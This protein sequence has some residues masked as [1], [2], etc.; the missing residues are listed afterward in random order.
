MPNRSRAI[1]YTLVVFLA[2]GLTGAVLMN[3]YEHFWRHP[4][5]HVVTPSSWMKADREHYIE[6]LAADLELTPAQ[7]TELESILDTTMQQFNDLHVF[8]HHIRQEGINRIRALL[9]EN[10]R[11]RFDQFMKS[12][13][14]PAEEPVSR[15]KP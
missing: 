11:K 5:G 6:K 15:K 10:Q 4:L 2:G 3:L 9:N 13:G 12:T 1:A 14:G 8:S 7:R